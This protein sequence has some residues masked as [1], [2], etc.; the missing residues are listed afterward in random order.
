MV[1]VPADTPVTSPRLVTVATALLEDTHGLEMAAVPLP[2][3]LVLNPK[4]TDAVAGS[5]V[6][7]AFTVIAAVAVHPVL[8]V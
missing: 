8:F 1:A 7:K 5:N 2:V 6:G 3:K 4:H